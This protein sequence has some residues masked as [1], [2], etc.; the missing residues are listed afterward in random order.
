MRGIISIEKTVAVK[1][2]VTA[3]IMPI[4]QS[5]KKLKYKNT[6]KAL[7]LSKAKIFVSFLR[8]ILVVKK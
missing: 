8:N 2:R 5:K 1:R 4:K 3:L 7:K 6:L